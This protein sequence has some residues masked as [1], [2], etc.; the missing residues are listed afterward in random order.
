MLFIFI[1][2]D[3]FKYEGSVHIVG[4]FYYLCVIWIDGKLWNLFKI[5]KNNNKKHLQ[6]RSYF[7]LR[8]TK[9]DCSVSEKNSTSE[10][11]CFVKAYSRSYTTVNYGF[12]LTRELNRFYVS[13]T[14]N[15]REFWFKLCQIDQTSTGLQIWNPLPTSFQSRSWMVWIDE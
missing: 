7:D 12:F 3:N 6:D 9:I 8:F 15:E 13:W 5:I 1:C 2:F 4:Y 11:F 10:H 14:I